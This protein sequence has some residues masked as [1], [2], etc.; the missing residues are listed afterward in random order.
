[1]DVGVEAQAAPPVDLDI[2]GFRAVVRGWPEVA[3]QVGLDFAYFRAP[4][5]LSLGPGVDIEVVAERKEPDYSRFA[6]L[7]ASFV[8]PR[9]VV[10]QAG[11]RTVID[12]FGRALSVFDRSAGRLIVQGLDVHLVHEAVYHFVL[13]QAA[14]ALEARGMVRLHCL[15][16]SAS[17]GA[18]AVMMPSGGGKSTLALRAL[19][20]DRVQVLSEDSPLVDRHGRLHPFPL[21]IGVN[22]DD[23]ASLPPGDT[24][25]IERMEFHPKIVLE[26]DAFRDRVATRP[27]PLRDLVIGRRTLGGRARLE[28]V[29]R[30]HALGTLLREAVVGVGL[31]QGMEFVLQRGALDVARQARP[32][33]IRAACCAAALRGARVWELHV[34]RDHDANWAALDPLI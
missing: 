1:V 16:L 32:G 6:A 22:V 28:R 34:G 9:N 13:S 14:A 20:D 3:E 17:G 24:R 33:M 2:H 11:D 25:V 26:F 31:Y 7:Q 10:Y 19:R 18:V 12:Y 5:S 29:P 21:R 4:S 8:T 23:A 30:R 27:V 15:G